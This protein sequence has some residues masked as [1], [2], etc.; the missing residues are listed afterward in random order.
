M[1]CWGYKLRCSSRDATTHR[2][3]VVVDRRGT[4]GASPTL[5]ARPVTWYFIANHTKL[6]VVSGSQRGTTT[7][8]NLIRIESC[9]S[10]TQTLP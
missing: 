10:E 5:C 2:T 8:K 9:P 1:A 6:D 7:V 4:V 3:R